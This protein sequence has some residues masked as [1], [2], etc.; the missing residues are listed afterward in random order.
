MRAE[1]RDW[2]ICLLC[3]AAAGQP[4]SASFYRVPEDLQGKATFLAKADGVIAGLAVADL[5]GNTDHQHWDSCCTSCLD[6]CNCYLMTHTHTLNNYAFRP[7]VLVAGAGLLVRK[8]AGALTE[9]LAQ[10]F[11]TVDPCLSV[12]WTRKDGD[13]VK[14]GTTFG[15]VKGSARS[16]L[17]AERIALNFMQRMSGIATAT[18]AMTDKMQASCSSYLLASTVLDNWI[19][20]P[21]GW[22]W[23][24][25]TWRAV[26]RSAQ[27]SV[28]LAQCKTKLPQKSSVHGHCISFAFPFASLTVAMLLII[29]LNICFHYWLPTN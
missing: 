27:G 12:Q 26:S 16:I 11:S 13:H 29:A 3:A 19:H 5:V 6:I 24:H 18:A 7:N 22:S 23:S 10:V 14:S 21:F 20:F 8:Q 4:W 15:I 17:V 28:K 1:K 25:K 2:P 9:R